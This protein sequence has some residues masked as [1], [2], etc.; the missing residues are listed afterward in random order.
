MFTR[1]P[2]FSRMQHYGQRF[3]G[4]DTTGLWWMLMMPGVVLTAVAIAIL[5]WPELL[6]YMVASLLLFAGVTLMTWGWRMRRAEQRIHQRL[7]TID[8]QDW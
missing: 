1:F 5:L 7:T 8:R 3:V 6:A 4:N 2:N